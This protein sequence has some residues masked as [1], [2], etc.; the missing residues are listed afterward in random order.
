MDEA[1]ITSKGQVTIPADVRAVVGVREGDK[2]LFVRMDDGSITLRSANLETTEAIRES[3]NDAF[4]IMQVSICN[5][6]EL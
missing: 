3:R 2:L 5:N 1:K 6:V 4:G